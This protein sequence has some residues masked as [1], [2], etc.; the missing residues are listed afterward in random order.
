[1]YYEAVASSTDTMQ[2][3]VHA[4]AAKPDRSTLNKR[5]VVRLCTKSPTF[6][7]V[8]VAFRGVPKAV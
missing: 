1:M 3:L 6:G 4:S 8:D 5:T 2:L 7:R